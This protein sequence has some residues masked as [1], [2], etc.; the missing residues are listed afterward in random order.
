MAWGRQQ[1][2]S[3][4]A[5]SC[6]SR[7][8]SKVRESGGR[9]CCIC[10]GTTSPRLSGPLGCSGSV[11]GR[12]R[13][14]PSGRVR[15]APGLRAPPIERRKPR[16]TLLW[17]GQ[18]TSVVR[19]TEHGSVELHHGGSSGSDAGDTGSLDTKASRAPSTSTVRRILVPRTPIS[20]G[21]CANGASPTTTSSS[22]MI[23][24]DIHDVVALPR[25]RKPTKTPAIHKSSSPSSRPTRTANRSQSSD[26]PPDLIAARSAYPRGAAFSHANTHGGMVGGAGFE[27]A[28]SS[29]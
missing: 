13:F 24:P 19:R 16:A 10:V 23:R 12:S 6:D 2:A 21:R 7:P 9:P 29:V 25:Q 26:S 22:G 3:S 18:R 1:V 4:S 5:Q 17:P 15:P 8:R 28:T 27:P 20:R 11:S 14:L